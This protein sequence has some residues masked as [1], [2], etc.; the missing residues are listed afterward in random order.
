MDCHPI[1][2]GVVVLLVTS[3]HGNKNKLWLNGS[4]GS[5]I[6]FLYPDQNLSPFGLKFVVL[7]VGYPLL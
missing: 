3:F 7:T 1:Q 6:D 5:S 4:L 2:G